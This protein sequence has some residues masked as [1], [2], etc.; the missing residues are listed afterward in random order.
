MMG[1]RHLVA[2]LW[3]QLISVSVRIKIL[4]MA[5]GLILLLGISLTLQMRAIQESSLRIELQRRGVALARDLAARATDYILLDD[6]YGLHN[7]LRD[8][9]MNN[10]DTVR[11]AF[12]LGSDGSPLAHT[13][14]D[15]FPRGLVD[16]NSVDRSEQYRMRRLRTNE[17]VIWDVAV[18]VPVGDGYTVRLGLGEAA[19][20]ATVEDTTRQFA[21]TTALV[22]LLGIL[23]AAGLTWMIT[24][25][26][27]RLAGA[28]K[29][30]AA[31][32]FGAR[33]VPFAD[34]EIGA[35]TRTFNRMTVELERAAHERE[36]RERLRALLIDKIITAQEEERRRISRELHD[37]T[38][39]ALTA[40]KMGLSNAMAICN[41]CA[42][43]ARLDELRD[44]VGQTLEGVRM[45]AHELRPP[46]LD[47]LGLVAAVRRYLYDWGRTFEV[48]VSFETFGMDGV[49]LAPTVET[50]VYRIVQEAL[51]NAARHSGAGRVDVVLERRGDEC[52]AIVEDGGRGFDPNA[53]D[54][55]RNL[56]LQG[57]MER[58]NL[59]GGQVVVESAPGRGTTVF[60]RVPIRAQGGGEGW[61]G[62][63]SAS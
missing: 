44:L 33:I 49:R 37:D 23:I 35:L 55:A 54:K 17:G 22:A 46:V 28:A 13:F 9:T 38:G 14:G 48:Q 25:P 63:Q 41:D 15:G 40:I 2:S 10:G 52:V 31:G 11:Y 32:D 21:L 3:R 45:L 58:A 7:L 53:V 60:V 39:Q 61:N 56:G 42:N 5:L 27:R 30:V 62:R 34:D 16:A 18:P 1:L 51:T 50:A 12:V 47:D 29:S 36:E 6:L 8:T 19:M 26:I 57:M 59:V 43:I 24:D 4:G 20:K